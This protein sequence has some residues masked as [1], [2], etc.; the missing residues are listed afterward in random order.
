MRCT[1]HSAPLFARMMFLAAVSSVTSGVI[2][3]AMAQDAV[4]QDAAN[5]APANAKV[6][7]GD[8]Y[9]FQPETPA[10]LIEAAAITAKLDRPGDGRAFLKK[11][12]DLQLGENDWQLLRNDLGP[13]PFL[14][15]RQDIRLHPE[16]E[17]LLAAVNAASRAKTWSANE[18]QALVEQLAAPGTTGVNA[19]TELISSGNAGFPYLLAADLS[20]PAGRIANDLIIQ[21]VYAFRS[22]LLSTL[23]EADPELQRRL[24]QILGTSGDSSLSVRLWRWQYAADVDPSVAEV[25]RTVVETLS[26][27]SLQPASGE[28][29]AAMLAT[30]AE[31]LLKQAGS[32]FSSLETPAELREL[33]PGDERTRQLARS[34]EL[35]DDSL[36]IDPENARALMV[37]GVAQS[38][39]VS[40]AL[41]AEATVAVGRKSSELLAGLEAALELHPVAAIEYLR[42]L[43]LATV[44][45]KELVEAGRVLRLALSSPDIRVRFLA[46]AIA[47]QQLPV[48]VS[49]ATVRRTLEA[50]QQGSVLPEVVII[51][52]DDDKLR[53]LQLVFQDANYWAQ[54]AETGPAGVDLAFSQ[55]NCELI[56]LDA[57][58]P[59]WPIATTLANLRADIRTRNT[60]VVVIG[61]D[62]FATRVLALTRTY[63]GVW[64]VAEPAGT[65]SLL[66]KI[67]QQ[68][69]PGFVLTAEDRA[70]MKTLAK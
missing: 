27:S 37:L 61:D 36:A 51:S 54:I 12:L 18:L 53:T 59:L 29:A 50:A 66:L 67:A 52:P 65:D 38:A 5:P 35:L 10:E 57:E 8:L 28:E 13:A 49:S 4:A 23:A 31:A 2:E 7:A 24:I 9:Q 33:A 6:I 16:S 1:N 21:N 47:D 25:A 20:T 70:A 15:L 14:E 30:E 11:L 45:E 34:L 42:G 55:M 58:A 17:Q 39:S 41:T 46:A 26:E 40:P 62:R 43:R 63:P 44:E 64:F 69:L 48:E 19:A 60:P 56:V 22:G 3:D 68:N 32:R